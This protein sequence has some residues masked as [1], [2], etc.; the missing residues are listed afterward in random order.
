MIQIFKDMM[1]AGRK[2]RWF[3]L[4]YVIYALIIIISTVWA[5]IRLDF[6][7]SYDIEQSQQI[8]SDDEQYKN[9]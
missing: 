2:A 1:H 6:V 3:W 9:N 7:R 8:Q 4:Q 5:Y